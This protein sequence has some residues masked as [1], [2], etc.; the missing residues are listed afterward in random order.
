MI[1]KKRTSLSR[2]IL[3]VS[4]LCTV[5]PFLVVG[6]AVH[7]LLYRVQM[8]YVEEKIMIQTDIISESIMKNNYLVS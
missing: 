8:Q 2:A 6:V 3:L 7:T 4:I 5:I 1:Q